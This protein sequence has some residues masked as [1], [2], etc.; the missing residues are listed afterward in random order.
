MVFVMTNSRTIPA[1][2]NSPLTGPT[3]TA[4]QSLDYPLTK[5]Y[6][7]AE[8]GQVRVQQYQNASTFRAVRQ[9]IHDIR[10]LGNFIIHHA[11]HAHICLIRGIGPAGVL[12]PTPRRKDIFPEHAD[13]T[14]WVMLDIDSVELPDDLSAHSDERDRLHRRT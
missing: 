12:T 6:S 10:A 8:D 11:K 1:A 9:N 2:Q 5:R 14:P 4:L 7:V 13:G 3:L